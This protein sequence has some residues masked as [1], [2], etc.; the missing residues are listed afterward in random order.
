MLLPKNLCIT[1]DLPTRGGSESR[2]SSEVV[3]ASKKYLARLCDL[4]MHLR[5]ERY[6]DRTMLCSTPHAEKPIIQP[7]AFRAGWR[8]QIKSD[9]STQG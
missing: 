6:R 3:L 2:G 4:L 9:A 5:E 7:Q 8:V 1:F